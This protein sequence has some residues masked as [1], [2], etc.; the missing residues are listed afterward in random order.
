MPIQHHFTRVET[1]ALPSDIGVPPT[2]GWNW[3]TGVA[4]SLFIKKGEE[5]NS[6]DIKMTTSPMG[7]YWRKTHYGFIHDDGNFLYLNREDFKT[8]HNF[9]IQVKF[10]G[11]YQK[12][13]D[14]AGIMLRVNE[15]QW[16]KTGIEFVNNVKYAS[17]VV[18]REFSDWSTSPVNFDSDSSWF[19]IRVELVKGDVRVEYSL[20]DGET[21]HLLRIAHLF[22]KSSE[23]EN[24]ILQLGI[25]ACSPTNENGLSVEFKGL[26]IKKL[27]L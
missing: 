18:T 23:S 22:D 6:L 20:D 7:D 4:Q 5:N 21:F 17:A 27:T 12:L 2:I 26:L 1:I 13:Y 24:D 16:I 9:E 11:D 3:A 14:Q 15:K 10:K 8:N 25:F 19:T